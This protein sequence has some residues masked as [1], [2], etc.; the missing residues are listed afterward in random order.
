MK[1]SSLGGDLLVFTEEAALSEE[2][3][4]NMIVMHPDRAGNFL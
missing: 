4:R 1:I 3:C 2:I